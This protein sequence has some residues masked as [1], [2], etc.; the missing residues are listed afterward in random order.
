MP[1]IEKQ[2]KNLNIRKFTK[3]K[4]TWSVIITIL[5]DN[6]YY[7]S[8][9]FQEIIK[10][11]FSNVIPW[12]LLTFALVLIVLKLLSKLTSN[13][14]PVFNQAINNEIF[15]IIDRANNEIFIVS[16]YIDPGNTITEKIIKRAKENIQITVIHKTD[17][18][19]KD[20]F[21]RFYNRL[22]ATNV[23]F[24]NNPSLH[25]KI[26]C[27]DSEALMTSMN[28]LTSSM[29]N[30]IESGI[31]LNYKDSYKA[32]RSHIVD[33]L[34]SDQTSLT[35]IDNAS[36]DLGYC[37]KSK[38]RI[39]FNPKK[40]VAFHVYKVD[41]SQKGQYCHKCGKEYHTT[42]NNPFCDEHSIN[43]QK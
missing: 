43:V 30:S 24:Y 9:H 34:N 10:L 7:K 4:Y 25:S 14:R 21:Q 40:P 15:E 8:Y 6:I 38:Q 33:I 36:T 27:N 37:I 12:F 16:P 23:V 3:S 39:N 20:E 2:R 17:Q 1:N 22:T 31:M 28:L 29:E 42:I 11:K 5:I 19:Q 13:S 35:N 26:Y 32:I 41:R 18:L